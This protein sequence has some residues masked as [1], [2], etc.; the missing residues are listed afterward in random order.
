[1]LTGETATQQGLPIPPFSFFLGIPL[2]TQVAAFTPGQNDLGVLTS[3]GV[4][5]VLGI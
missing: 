1:M 3:N 5:A 2:F 4:A